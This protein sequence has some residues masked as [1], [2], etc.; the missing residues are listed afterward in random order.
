[1]EGHMADTAENVTQRD[2]SPSFPVVGLKVAFERLVEFETYFKRSAA[3]PEKVGDAWS[4]T[5]KAYAD[6]IAAALRYFGLLEYQGAGKERTIAISEEGRKYLRAQQEETKREVIKAA[7]LRPKQIAECWELWSNDRPADAACIDDLV[8]NRAFSVAGARDFL[9][10]YDSTI[11]YAGLTASDKV[12]PAASTSGDEEALDGPKGK[13]G[14]GF[15]PPPP[16]QPVGRVK[17]MDGERIVF[18]EE[19]NPQN[20]LKLIA[21]GDVDETMLEALE[22]YVKRQKKR[23]IAAYQAGVAQMAVSGATPSPSLLS[24]AVARAPEAAQVPFMITQAQKEALRTKG[25]D[26]DQIANMKP[27]KAHQLLGMLPPPPY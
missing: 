27:E 3:R 20:Y 24:Q 12:D 15:T 4:I 22:D 2:R 17:L 25:F 5:T 6:R 10:V 9:K 11:S 16:F 13:T 21:S 8:Q 26:D 7:A 18:T 23:L 14:T 19:S 1:M